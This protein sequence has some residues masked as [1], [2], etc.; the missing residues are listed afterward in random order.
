MLITANKCSTRWQWDDDDD[1]DIDDGGDDSDDDD[2]LI[3]VIIINFSVIS[4]QI[5]IYRWTK[6]WLNVWGTSEHR[7][8]EYN[9]HDFWWKPAK[10]V[11]EILQITTTTS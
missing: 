7:N 11:I 6:L 10:E 3:L 1:D 8:E 9:L 2:V 5:W 4:R